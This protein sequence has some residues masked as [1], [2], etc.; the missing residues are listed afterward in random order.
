MA[1][2][3]SGEAGKEYVR[4][5]LLRPVGDSLRWELA[6][7][8]AFECNAR[9]LV[10][11]HLL[12]EKPDSLGPYVALRIG[13]AE[14]V[15]SILSYVS[16]YGCVMPEYLFLVIADTLVES[17]DYAGAVV[18]LRRVPEDLPEAADDRRSVLL[19][20]GLLGTGD[21]SGAEYILA[22][23]RAGNDSRLESLLRHYLGAWKFRESRGGFR[24]EFVESF[25]LWPAAPVHAAAYD[26][27]RNEILHDSSLAASIADCFYSG[28]LWNELYDMARNSNAPD[29]HL[30]YLAARTRDRLG[31]YDIAVEMLKEYMERW[32]G[33]R[34]IR[35]VMIYLGR[36]LG[37]S[38]RPDEGSKVLM[39]YG[40][41]YPDHCRISNLPWYMGDLY[42]GNRIWK[43][44][45]PWF[46]KTPEE[47]PGNVTA[48]DAHFYLC[49]SL[50]KTGDTT[51]AVAEL[52]RFIRRWP[53]SV[54][55][56][57]AEY[58]LGRILYRRGDPGGRDILE[59]LA[60]AA[61]DGLPARFARDMLGLPAWKPEVSEEPLRHWMRRHGV[62]PAEPPQE[63]LRGLFLQRAGL[64]GYAVDEFLAGEEKVGGPRFLAPFYLENDVWE[65]KP[66]SGYVM[67]NLGGEGE[68][69]PRELW[70]LRYQ[71]AWPELV[72]PASRRYGIDPLFIWAIMRNESMFRPSTYSVAGARG[73]I[74]M[75]PSTSE[76]VALENGWDDFSPD[77]LYD[78]EVSIEYGTCYIAGLAETMGGNPVLTAAAYNG[79]PHNATH[80]GAFDMSV[81]E[82]YSLITYNE[83]KNY[84][85][86]VNHDFQVYS[87]LYGDGNTASCLPARK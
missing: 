12:L 58:W 76:Y 36:N 39:E 82:F 3:F 16:R 35:D 10:T 52:R 27:I 30:W 72:I 78:P 38:G 34:D 23:V 9:S 2:G 68:A 77:R 85:R 8:S 18:A 6:W 45:I 13:G 17:G 48:D 41:D 44:A 26:L 20:R 57:S 7:K 61:S 67:W 33:G 42:A 71:E 81:E 53:G 74:Q 70:M 87:F 60:D 86:K 28:G 49:F 66:L 79:G 46:R 40:E 15:P 11:A 59:D 50:M 55:L 1:R 63:T 69:R 73:L 31:F 25:R 19:F 32:P 64:R 65:R 56:S 62:I 21:V 80:W 37:R 5:A 43:K 75:I 54:Y 83:T 51:A 24:E 22:K 4:A 84:T 47:Y 14:V 29:P